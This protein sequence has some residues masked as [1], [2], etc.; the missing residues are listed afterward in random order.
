[1]AV[2][3]VHPRNRSSEEINEEKEQLIQ[4]FKDNNI[5]IH[6]LYYHLR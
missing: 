1:M 4:H 5:Q 3:V 6:S 2:V